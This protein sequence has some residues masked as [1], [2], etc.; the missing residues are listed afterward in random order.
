MMDD[1][2]QSGPNIYSISIKRSRRDLKTL[3]DIPM[4]NMLPTQLANSVYSDR[5]HGE[6][7]RVCLC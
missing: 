7:S 4:L 2:S 3:F 5:V 6:L 1:E